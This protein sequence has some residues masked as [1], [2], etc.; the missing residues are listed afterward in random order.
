[1]H[2]M[3]IGLCVDLG[4]TYSVLGYGTGQLWLQQFVMSPRGKMVS[5]GQKSV[6]KQVGSLPTEQQNRATG[7]SNRPNNISCEC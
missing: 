5:L 3:L 1:M 2:G 6:K 7:K 4:Q